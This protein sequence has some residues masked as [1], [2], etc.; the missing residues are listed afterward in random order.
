MSGTTLQYT[1]VEPQLQILFSNKVIFHSRI[2]NFSF[3]LKDILIIFKTFVDYEDDPMFSVILL[4]P[5]NFFCTL[6]I[7]MG[8]RAKN[9]G[10]SF[11]I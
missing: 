1:D 4:R 9:D 7:N 8:I 10:A 2:V 11:S 6:N 3:G 5:T